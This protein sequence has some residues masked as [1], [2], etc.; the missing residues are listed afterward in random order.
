[1]T[2]TNQSDTM[3]E[4]RSAPDGQGTF[5]ALSIHNF[6]R[7]L[8]GDPNS[9]RPG[10]LAYVRSMLPGWMW[11]LALIGVCYGLRFYP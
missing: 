5:K 4:A 8:L 7:T 11:I 1:M 9:T 2:Q 3:L 10:S 6:K